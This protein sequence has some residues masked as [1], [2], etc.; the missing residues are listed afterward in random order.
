[1][2]SHAWG[3]VQPS[4]WKHIA[5]MAALFGHRDFHPWLANVAEDFGEAERNGSTHIV[6]VV[7][8]RKGVHRSISGGSVLFHCVRMDS[9]VLLASTQHTSALLWKHDHCGECARCR[10]PSSQCQDA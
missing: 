2:V 3:D 7:Y 6:F 4:S 10:A 1:M 9:R 8:C 5:N